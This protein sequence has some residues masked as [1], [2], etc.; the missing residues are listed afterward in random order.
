[1]SPYNSQA[2]GIVEHKHFNIHKFLRRCVITNL[3][4]GL[5]WLPSY[6]GPTGSLFIG[7]LVTPHISWPTVWRWSHPLTLQKQHI[8]FPLL[9][10]LLQL[11]ISFPTVPNSSRKDWKIFMT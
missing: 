1:M 4:N 7:Q 3:Q 10:F 2:N 5:T 8:F 6:F 9:M 11:R